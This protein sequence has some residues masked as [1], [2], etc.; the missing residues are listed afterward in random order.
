MGFA[1]EKS[2]TDPTSRKSYEG[3]AVRKSRKGKEWS[4]GSV[5]SLFASTFG[6]FLDVVLTKAAVL[7]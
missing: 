2:T 5:K 1:G 4:V 3:Q 6:S 7:P